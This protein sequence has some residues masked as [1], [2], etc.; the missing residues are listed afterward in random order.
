MPM[1][2]LI[3]PDFGADDCLWDM[4]GTGIDIDSVPMSVPAR[5]TLRAWQKQWDV[6]AMQDLEAEA[7][8]DGMASGSTE[9]VSASEWKEHERQGHAI[10]LEIHQ[11]L[12][13]QWQVGWLHLVGDVRRVQWS[14]GGPIEPFEYRRGP[15]AS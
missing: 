4:R 11:G 5:E 6:L 2:L 15:P 7:I 8:A 10:W 13:P 12:D 14:P 9:P 3:D 1:R